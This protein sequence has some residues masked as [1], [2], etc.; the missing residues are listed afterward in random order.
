M[1]LSSNSKWASLP[2]DLVDLILDNLVPMEDVNP[3]VP[4]I[5]VLM[6]TNQGYWLLM[7]KD[8]LSDRLKLIKHQ[9]KIIQAKD[10]ND[11]VDQAL[12][13]EVHSSQRT[14]K[15]SN[16]DSKLKHQVKIL[17]A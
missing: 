5:E 11:V 6:I 14:K 15:T 9:M 7:V 3:R 17:I 10:D 16:Q 12:G 13:S 2:I 4:L 8:E 1:G